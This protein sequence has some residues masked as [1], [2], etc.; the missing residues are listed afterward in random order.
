VEVRDMYYKNN[1]KEML[2]LLP[3]QYSRVLEIGCGEGNFR[4][5][6]KLGYEFW[7]VEPNEL[8]AIKA[9]KKWIKF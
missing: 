5:N 6:L 8:S 3:K 7:G 4:E 2:L 1:R 9:E